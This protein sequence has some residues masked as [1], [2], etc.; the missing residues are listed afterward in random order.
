MAWAGCHICHHYKHGQMMMISPFCF[1]FSSVSRDAHPAVFTTKFIQ[2][3]CPLSLLVFLQRFLPSSSWQHLLHAHCYFQPSLFL[4]VLTTFQCPVPCYCL[5][6][7][8]LFSSS[9]P[10]NVASHTARGWGRKAGGD[11]GLFKQVTS[12]RSRLLPLLLW[13]SLCTH[14][15]GTDPTF[16][17]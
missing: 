13:L 12:H 1:W 9:F 4:E 17:F 8:L 16:I 10:P 15:S 11:Q 5:P 3:I 2:L 14:P 7:A 6:P